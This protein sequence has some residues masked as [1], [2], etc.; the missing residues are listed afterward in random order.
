[1]P[2]S[3]GIESARRRRKSYNQERG[4][5]F[6][7]NGRRRKPSLAKSF[8]RFIVIN[9]RIQES[10]FPWKRM[11]MRYGYARDLRELL[12]KPKNKSKFTVKPPSHIT[13]LRRWKF[14]LPNSARMEIL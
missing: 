6:A 14:A 13:P 1:M 3:T 10:F 5:L 2:W 9:K 12:N 7:K 11:S 4:I 8:D